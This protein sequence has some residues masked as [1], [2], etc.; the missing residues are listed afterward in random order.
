MFLPRLDET[1][2][3]RFDSTRVVFHRLYS[4]HAVDEMNSSKSRLRGMGRKLHLFPPQPL[5]K[6]LLDYEPNI[7][8]E[9]VLGNIHKTR[10]EVAVKVATNKQTAS[11]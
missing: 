10:K 8:C 1:Y 7:C 3:L 11:S 5:L 9:R 6:K 4:G 2:H